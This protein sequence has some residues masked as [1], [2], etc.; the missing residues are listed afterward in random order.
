MPRENGLYKHGTLKEEETQ[1]L[2]EP[3]VLSCPGSQ[4]SREEQDWK[5]TQKRQIYRQLPYSV[6]K[7]FSRGNNPEAFSLKQNC[8]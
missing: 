1:Y 3:G 2:M 5:A 4:G 6:C 7:T 8:S